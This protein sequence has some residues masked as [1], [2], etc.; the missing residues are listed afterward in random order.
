MD[1][2]VT[3]R[4]G[5]FLFPDEAHVHTS[6]GTAPWRLLE[7][8]LKKRYRSWWGSLMVRH[9]S[10]LSLLWVTDQVS[11]SINS[12]AH[13]CGTDLMWQMRERP[14]ST[15]T[16]RQLAKAKNSVALVN[17][18]FH[19]WSLWQRSREQWYCNFR[20]THHLSG[21]LSTFHR[22]PGLSSITPEIAC[23]ITQFPMNGHKPRQMSINS[24]KSDGVPAHSCLPPKGWGFQQYCFH[25]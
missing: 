9:F 12:A 21:Y 6:I 13:S 4:L 8:Q 2:I 11:K 1:F 22:D 3:R 16:S 24:G 14:W 10:S 18:L 20:D 15:D 19:C 17:A 23:L 25:R 7:M 5:I